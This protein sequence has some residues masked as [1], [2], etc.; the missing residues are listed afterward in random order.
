MKSVKRAVEAGA[1]AER[2]RG[3]SMVEV[4]ISV[5]LLGLILVGVMGSL[6]TSF[7]AQR[8]NSDVMQCQLLTQQVMEEVQS[9]PYTDLLSFNGT[10]LDDTSGKHRARITASLQGANLVRIEVNTTSLDHP[11]NTARAVTMIAN[12]N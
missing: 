2:T 12:M 3:L 6:S 8:T 4:A 1:P 9:T 10:F 7:I 11:Q 5:S